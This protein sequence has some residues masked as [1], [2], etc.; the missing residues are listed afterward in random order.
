MIPSPSPHSAALQHLPPHLREV[1]ALLAAGLLR[2]RSRAAEELA[3]DAAEARDRGEVRLHSA[4]WQRRHAN[5]T[6]RRQA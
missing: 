3:R 6:R 2:L 4:P 5:P 1:C